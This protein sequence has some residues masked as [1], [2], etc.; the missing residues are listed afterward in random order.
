MSAMSQ[1]SNV[2]GAIHADKQSDPVHRPGA[3]ERL[4]ILKDASKA[5]TVT[6]DEFLGNFDKERDRKTAHPYLIQ[7]VIQDAIRAAFEIPSVS[8]APDMTLSIGELVGIVGH[9][10]TL[11]LPSHTQQERDFFIAFRAVC[12]RR[13]LSLRRRDASGLQDVQRIIE[14]FSELKRL[15]ELQKKYVIDSIHLLGK[16]I[17][18]WQE[19][20]L[21]ELWHLIERASDMNVA[22]FSFQVLDRKTAFAA[23]KSRLNAPEYHPDFDTPLGAGSRDSDGDLEAGRGDEIEIT[24]PCAIPADM[25][26]SFQ[27]REA[28][29]HTLVKLDAELMARVNLLRRRD[30]M[31]FSERLT[32]ALKSVLA[33]GL[34][35]SHGTHRLQGKGTHHKDEPKL[36]RPRHVAP[37]DFGLDGRPAAPEAASAAAATMAAQAAAEAAD[38]HR[39]SLKKEVDSCCS[40]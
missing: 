3:Q 18:P 20:A 2:A 21:M 37:G 1:V 30:R 32:K 23:A 22:P 19:E 26:A 24:G 33:L 8:I 6:M 31:S 13:L 27:V 12:R 40:E 7:A 39:Q 28:M 9:A 10:H 16:A 36:S 25:R 4:L 14:A 29:K 15:P 35:Y 34:E 11:H 38:R 5:S 17:H